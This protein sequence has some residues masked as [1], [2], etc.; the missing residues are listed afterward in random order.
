MY[1]TIAEQAAV[2]FYHLIK[3]HPFLNGNKRIACVALTT[4][5][6]FN[7]KWPK[8]PPGDF[9]GIALKVA[10]SNPNDRARVIEILSGVFNR[11]VLDL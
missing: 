11:I 9:Y 1:K 6:Y 7:K 8:F 5:F 3:A 2:L 10:E 4:F